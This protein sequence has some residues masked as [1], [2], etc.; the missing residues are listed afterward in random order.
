M[1]RWLLDSVRLQDLIRSKA[2]FD[3]LVDFHWNYYSELALQRNRI[4][5]QLRDSLREKAEPFEFE[6]W[7]RLG[8]L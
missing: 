5:D 8:N 7:Q 2:Y 6:K 3:G 1:T 4:R